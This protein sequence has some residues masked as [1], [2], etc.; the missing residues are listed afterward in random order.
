MKSLKYTIDVLYTIISNAIYTIMVARY[1]LVVLLDMASR[2]PD[3]V[4]LS[5]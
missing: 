3:Y 5:Y 4:L 1:G 2:N